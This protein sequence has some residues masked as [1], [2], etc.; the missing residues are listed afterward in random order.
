MRLT[1]SIPEELVEWAKSMAAKKKTSMARYVGGLLE[2]EMRR[3]TNARN[4]AASKPAPP[5]DGGEGPERG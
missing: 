1:V 3:D 5:N 2:E 4:A